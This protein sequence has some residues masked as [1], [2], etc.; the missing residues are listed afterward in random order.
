MM[1][2]ISKFQTISHKAERCRKYSIEFKKATIKY[3]QENSIQIAMK[4]KVNQKIACEWVQKE[5]KLTS[6]K[7]KRFRLDSG[8][9]KLT[10]VELEV[11]SWI[12][13]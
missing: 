7:G 5:K 12:Q 11:L 10:G 6:M 2:D 4:F 13:Q 9:Q 8:G 1:D 3:V